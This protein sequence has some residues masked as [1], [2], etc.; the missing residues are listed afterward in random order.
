MMIGPNCL[1]IVNPHFRGKF[2]GIQP[3]TKAGTIDIISAS[4]ATVDYIFEQADLRGIKF[5]NIVSMGNSA[6]STVE[7][8]L[9]TSGRNAQ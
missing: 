7:D 4:G 2:A 3:K 6:Q 1:G 9:E 8:M 5:D